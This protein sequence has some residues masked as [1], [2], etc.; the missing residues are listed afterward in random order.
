MNHSAWFS[1]LKRTYL[2]VNDKTIRTRFFFEGEYL[3]WQRFDRKRGAYME[4]VRSEIGKKQS[5]CYLVPGV[6]ISGGISVILRHANE[7][8]KRGYD[9]KILS[10]SKTNDTNWYPKQRVPIIPY[11]QARV[12]LGNGSIEILIATAYST[13]YTVDMAVARRKLYFIQSDESRFFPADKRLTE[14]IW[15]TYSLPLEQVVAVSWLKKWLKY[16]FGSEAVQV[17]NGLDTT[18]FHQAD[19][20]VAKSGRM[21]VLIEGGIDIPYKGM[22]EAYEAVKSLDCE[23]WIVSNKGAPSKA[24]KCDRFF[25]SVPMDEMP[26]IYSSCDILLK[27]STVESFSYPP[28]E[29]MACG[30]IPVIR[31]VTGIEEY[32]VHEHNCLIVK[33]VDGARDAVNRLLKDTELRKKL[34]ENGLKTAG[35]WNWDRSVDVLEAV[36]RGTKSGI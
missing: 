34:I 14:K 29:M 1:I 21:R 4:P 24:W 17:P 19:P 2:Y 12:L 26:N 13:A 9:V 7:L 16:E 10:L 35:E 32:A 28:L 15:R 23:I 20:I 22:A 18:I 30:G 3:R 36:I 33:D 11:R 25:G 8:L 5:I 6:A 31:E 27:M